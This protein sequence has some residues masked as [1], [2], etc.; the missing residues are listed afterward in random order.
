MMNSSAHRLLEIHEKAERQ[1]VSQVIGSPNMLQLLGCNEKQMD[2]EIQY[3]EKIM[4]VNTQLIMERDKRIGIVASFRDRTEIKH[5]I[6][7]LSEVKQY[8]ADLRAQAHEF[9]N[10]LYAILGLLQ[11]NKKEV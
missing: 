11:L 2:V 9:T 7:A 5:M 10:K 3:R 1:H 4:I 8:S 6:D